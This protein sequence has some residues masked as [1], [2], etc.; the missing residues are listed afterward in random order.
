MATAAN[1]LFG[2]E[3][4]HPAFQNSPM[5]LTSMAVGQ[6]QAMELARGGCSCNDR[7]SAA[8]DCRVALL[9]RW[10]WNRSRIRVKSSHSHKPENA[11]QRNITPTVAQ[12]V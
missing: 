5:S 1:R 12:T 3:F 4:A 11:H 8:V 10:F 7:V 6:Q 2:V 9:H